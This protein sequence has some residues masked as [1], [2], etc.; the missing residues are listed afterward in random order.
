MLIAR[1][2]VA[3]TRVIASEHSFV[4]SK[5]PRRRPRNRNRDARQN[6][7]LASLAMASFIERHVRR[8]RM[9]VKF[10]QALVD[11][12]HPTPGARRREI[13]RDERIDSS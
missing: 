1:C 6:H 12:E 8:A 13:A 5:R 10:D 11:D 3:S 7:P 9:V 2:P 4:D